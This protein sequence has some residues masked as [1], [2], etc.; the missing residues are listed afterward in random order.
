MSDRKTCACCGE[1]KPVT[2]FYLSAKAKDGR[3]SYCKSCA[4]KSVLK[5][6]AEKQLASTYK[7]LHKYEDKLRELS[8]LRALS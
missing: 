4:T 1:T 5:G 8:K 6:R 2:E 3:Q 7:R